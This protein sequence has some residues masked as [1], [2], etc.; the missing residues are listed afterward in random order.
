MTHRPASVTDASGQTT[1]FTW[2]SKRQLTGKSWSRVVGG[3]SVSERIAYAYESDG[4]VNTSTANQTYG[5]L[6]QI[7]GDVLE[8][9]LR[10]NYD[11]WAVMTQTSSRCHGVARL[12][13][14]VARSVPWGGSVGAMAVSYTHLTLPTNREV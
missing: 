4:D 5:Q 6:R 14:I 1:S 8:A 12:E 9:N 11:S 2:N 13:A 7:T 10:F 3:I